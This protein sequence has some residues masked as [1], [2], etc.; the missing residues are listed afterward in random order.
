MPRGRKRERRAPRRRDPNAPSAPTKRPASRTAPP[1][2]SRTNG[3]RGARS[4]RRAPPPPSASRRQPSP[5][6]SGDGSARGA[7]RR[8]A[9]PTSAGRPAVTATARSPRDRSAP[10][11]APS[12][13]A[14]RNRGLR[15]FPTTTRSYSRYYDPWGYGAFGLGYFYYSPWAGIRYGYGGVRLRLRLRLLRRP[16]RGAYGYDVGSVKLKVQ[17]ARRRGVGRRLLRG[18]GRRFRRH[19]P[20]A[21]ARQRRVS[22][23]GPQAGLRDAHASTCACSRNGTITFRGDMRRGSLRVSRSAVCRSRARFAAHRSTKSPWRWADGLTA[24]PTETTT[25]VRPACS[26]YRW[27]VLRGIAAISLVYDRLRRAR[28]R[29]PSRRSCKPGS[30][31]RRGSACAILVDLHRDLRD[32]RRGRLPAAATAIPR[33][34]ART[35]GSSAWR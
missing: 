5:R 34:I 32:V 16:T 30:A 26:P 31:S 23:R 25:I 12:R 11:R 1:A 14:D 17:A 22:H 3:R 20:V 10:S 2:R 21:Q 8:G 24:V 7:V 35:C 19:V 29:L 18:H 13:A 9:P 33:A 15:L 28:A 27:R 4:S 6:D